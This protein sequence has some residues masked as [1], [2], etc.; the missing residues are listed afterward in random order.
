M[1]K[2]EHALS[3]FSQGYSCSQAVLATYA[4]ELGLNHEVAMRVAAG[5]GGGLGRSGEVC[6]A[7][8]GA[9]MVLGMKYGSPTAGNPEAKERT[10]TMSQTFCRE[11][12]ARHK[13]ILCRELLG[14]DLSTPEGLN[15]ARE[16]K[17]F[18]NQCPKLVGDAVNILET[19][20]NPLNPAQPAAAA[21]QPEA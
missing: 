21:N 2:S 16:K 1:T 15:W 8:T 14:C 5:F 4:P 20:T 6:G 10:Y 11:F 12:K 3:R 7:V 19:L 18:V 17:L 9:I 13:T